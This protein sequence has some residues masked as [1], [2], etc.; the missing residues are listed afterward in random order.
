MALKLDAARNRAGDPN[1]DEILGELRGETQDA[2]ADVR[3]VV[4]ELRPPALDELGLVGALQAQAARLSGQDDG[5]HRL[6]VEVLAPET[7]P[8]LPAAVEVAAYRIATEALTNAVRHARARHCTVRLRMN[9]LLE[10]EVADDGHGVGASSPGVGLTSMRERADELGGSCS[11]RPGPAG[12]TV[13][14]AELPL[15]QP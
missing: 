9:G 10:V 4:Y 13:V 1:V 11:V 5:G 2:I 6:T 14:R 12:G 7:M 15:E 8:P 3:R